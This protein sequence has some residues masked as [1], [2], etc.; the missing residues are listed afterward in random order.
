MTEPV[1]VVCSTACTVTHVLSVDPGV[2]LPEQVTDYMA[3][4][5]LFLGAMVAVLVAKV[6]YNRFRMDY[7]ER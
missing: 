1:T 3:L 7:G 4:W 6:I 5:M 2:L